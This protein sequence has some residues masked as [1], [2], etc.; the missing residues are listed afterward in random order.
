[1]FARSELLSEHDLSDYVCD[2]LTILLSIWA[3]YRDWVKIEKERK[4]GLV[5]GVGERRDLVWRD[6]EVG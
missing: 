4:M 1:M 5:G 3:G 6:E 2:V